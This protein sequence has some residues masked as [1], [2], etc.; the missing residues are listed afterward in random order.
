MRAQAVRRH[1]GV[2]GVISHQ[3]FAAGAVLAGQHRRFPHLRMLGQPGLDLAQ[4]DAEAAD[5]D[6][7]IVAAEE[8]DTTILQPAAQVAGLVQPGFGIV[9]E[10]IL[11]KAFGVQLGPVQVTPRQSGA[12]Y[13][14]LA[15]DTDRNGFEMR[16][17]QVDVGVGDG[18]ADRRQAFF[19]GR[20]RAGGRNHAVLGGAVVVDQ[21][22]RQSGRRI[23]V[24]P[25]AAGQQ[26]AQGQLFGPGGRQ[27]QFRQRRRHERHRDAIVGQPLPQRLRLAQQFGPDQVQ[28][29]AGQQV[30]PGFP[31]AGVEGQARQLRGP[32]GGAHLELPV[33]PADQVHHAGVRHHDALG[34]PGGTGGVDHIGQMRRSQAQRVRRQVRVRLF[35]DLAPVPVQRNH[36]SFRGRQVLLKVLLR[37]QHPGRC[38]VQHVGQPVFRIGRIQRHVSAAR[39]QDAQQPH[40]HFQTALHADRNQNVGAYA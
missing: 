21:F 33:V 32:V 37:Q 28:A 20:H 1:V 31:G 22:E 13:I 4:L 5:L 7:E 39:F 16:V 17:Q 18:L 23:A 12:A 19:S 2:A 24:Q 36:L 35:G 8:L 3:P 15:H 34:L 27:H 10:R 38:I 6:L 11:D 25:V 40:Y 26:A 14:Q 29:G 9:A 30:R